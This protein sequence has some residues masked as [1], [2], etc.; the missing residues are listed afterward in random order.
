MLPPRPRPLRISSSTLQSP[1][2]T[3]GPSS[4]PPTLVWARSRMGPRGKQPRGHLPNPMAGLAERPG[5]G[6][7][8]DLI[9]D[10]PGGPH[11]S[12]RT[13]GL[14]PTAIEPGLASDLHRDSPGPPYMVRDREGCRQRIGGRQDPT[15]MITASVSVRDWSKAAKYEFIHESCIFLIIPFQPYP[16]LFN[17]KRLIT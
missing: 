12:W 3:F 15:R 1:C 10:H 9:E 6:A 16:L 11:A 14:W 2:S 5:G 13:S 4:T 7:T 17:R 8:D